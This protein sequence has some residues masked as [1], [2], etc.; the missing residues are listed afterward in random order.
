MVIKL[1]H[2]VHGTKIAISEAEAEADAREGWVRGPEQVVNELAP[3]RRRIQ[4][5]VARC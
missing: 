1:Y 4:G 3:K 2:P 5:A